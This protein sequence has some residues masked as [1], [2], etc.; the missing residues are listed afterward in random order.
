MA[1]LT[2]WEGLVSAGMAVVITI[3]WVLADRH[4]EHEQGATFLKRALASVVLLIGGIFLL[5]A[6][7]AA[8]QTALTGSVFS[9]KS[10]VHQLHGE[11]LA[12]PD[13]F[14]WEK[15]YA[16]YELVRDNPGLYP[17]LPIYLW[18]HREQTAINY[19][20]NTVAQFLD[21]H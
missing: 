14:A 3:V 15:S 5:A 6:P 1:H 20:R 12:S 11:A 19:V 8:Y 18:E 4:R 9:T 21:L 16:N 7:Y 2:R 10:I 13:P 17:P